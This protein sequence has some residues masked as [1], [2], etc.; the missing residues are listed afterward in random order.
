MGTFSSRPQRLSA[1]EEHLGA[2][3]LAI[4]V[5]PNPLGSYRYLWRLPWDPSKPPLL[6]VGLMPSTADETHADP[7][8]AKFIAIAS[9]PHHEVGAPNG[10]GELVVMNMFARRPTPNHKQD[11][12]DLMFVDAVGDNDTWI[13]REDGRIRKRRGTV[14]VAWGADGWSR[15]GKVL[16]LLGGEVW[17][18]GTTRPL[19]K[20]SPDHRGFPLSA[21]RPRVAETATFER[22]LGSPSIH[23]LRRLSYTERRDLNPRPPA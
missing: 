4:Q 19:R 21:S 3:G 5:E 16:S 1:I 20:G 22:Y 9:T 8:I 2:R 13:A 23:D 7:T 12:A 15:H 11:A 14:A 6:V 18:F 17:C 10:F